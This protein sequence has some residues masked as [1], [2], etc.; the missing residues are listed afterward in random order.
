MNKL[1]DYLLEGIDDKSLTLLHESHNKELLKPDSS[2][3]IYVSVIPEKSTLDILEC[4]TKDLMFLDLLGK[5]NGKVCD[6]DDY[7]T[8]IVYSRQGGQAIYDLIHHWGFDQNATVQENFSANIDPIRPLEFFGHFLVC[9]LQ[10]ESLAH[11]HDECLRNSGTFDFDQYNPHI[12]IAKVDKE[13]LS[14]KEFA[15]LV[16]YIE[17]MNSQDA[18]ELS[19]TQFR[20]TSM[21]CEPLDVNRA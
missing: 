21:N 3:S 20:F 1:V 19:K 14:S 7:H 15:E 10:S 13:L 17:L 4:F 6:I 11:F 18:A 2:D 16:D 8:T 9:K 12:T 5:L